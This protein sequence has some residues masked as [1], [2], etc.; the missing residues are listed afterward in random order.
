MLRF[1]RW[2]FIPLLLLDILLIHNFVRYGLP[3]E[4]VPVQVQQPLKPGEVV[5][6]FRKIPPS[7]QDWII[8]AILL[9]V[10]LVVFWAFWARRKDSVPR[11][12]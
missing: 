6:Q 7:R 2:I 4:S 11:P 10:H 1:L 8:A 12:S 3:V 9:A 5:M